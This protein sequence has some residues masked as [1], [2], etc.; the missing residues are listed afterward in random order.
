MTA[1]KT[2]KQILDCWKDIPDNYI[3]SIDKERMLAQAILEAAEVINEFSL[4]ED[5]ND[6]VIDAGAR[7]A[8]AWLAKHGSEE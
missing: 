1:L 5:F 2:A 7:R 8:C 4:L 6:A 3:K